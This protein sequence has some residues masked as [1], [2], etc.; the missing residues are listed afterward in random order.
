MVMISLYYYLRQD[1]LLDFPCSVVSFTL[2]DG[3]N[4]VLKMRNGSEKE[5]IV[6]G[7]SYVSAYLTVLIL[8]PVRYWN[9]RSVIILPDSVDAEEFRRLRILLRWKW[10]RV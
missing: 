4:C 5:C 7:T 6:L 9:L 1:A 2:T 3:K 8:Q 10:E